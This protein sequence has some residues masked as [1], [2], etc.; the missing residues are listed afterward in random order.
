MLGLPLIDHSQIVIEY[1]GNPVNCHT[2]YSMTPNRVM[3]IAI[4]FVPVPDVGQ[5]TE[6][7]RDAMIRQQFGSQDEMNSFWQ[8][9]SN[10]I[11]ANVDIDVFVPPANTTTEEIL[12]QFIA[13]VY[14]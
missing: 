13:M 2:V 3:H 7:D 6:S 11:R 10:A 12:G 9:L 8:G 4:Y 1:D 14:G 5:F